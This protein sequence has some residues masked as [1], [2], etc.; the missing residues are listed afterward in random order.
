M[1]IQPVPVDAAPPVPS[2]GDPEETFDPAF[3]ASL[4]WQREKLRPQMNALAEVTYQNTVEAVAAKEDAQDSADAAAASVTAA[5]QLVVAA[6]EQADGAAMSAQSAQVAAAAAGAAAGLPALAGK[7]TQMLRVRADEQGVEFAPVPS[8]YS[9]GDSIFTARVLSEPVWV[10][11]GG[12]YL[13]SA[14]PALLAVAGD[15]APKIWR[16]TMTDIGTSVNSYRQAVA[17]F[18]AAG[19]STFVAVGGAGSAYGGGGSP[20][21]MYS[22]DGGLTWASCSLGPHSDY[23]RV[24]AWGTAGYAI[25]LGN[26]GAIAYTTN[27]YTWTKHTAA[28]TGFNP[29][30]LGAVS[31]QTFVAV[32]DAGQLYRTLNITTWTK[33][34]GPNAVDSLYDVATLTNGT[35]VLVV[36]LKGVIWRS[37]DSGATWAKIAGPNT[38]DD[39][40]G[41]AAL[42]A[43][44]AV[45]VGFLGAVWRTTDAGVTWTKVT[46]ANIS[47][48]LRDIEVMD[49]SRLVAVGEKGAVWLSSDAGLTWWA[50]DKSNKPA[51][52]SLFSV[53][54]GASGTTLLAVGAGSGYAW[55]AGGIQYDPATQF[56]APYMTSPPGTNHYIKA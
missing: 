25:A 15:S 55:R 43:T 14:Y 13:K 33:I 26:N 36:G 18:G 50:L 24:V 5:G 28:I 11:A 22:Q 37:T 41:V 38:V 23:Y 17:R 6:G 21:G 16:R 12:V 30:G 1:P 32:G 7:A 27:A 39:L 2:S 35:T 31:G 54:C 52:D 42:S 51:E 34:E 4:T 8:Q 45:A 19:S 46:G 9:T 49:A 10:K 29:R 20:N 53:A 48:N 47:D 3:E 56:V 40:Y 44:V